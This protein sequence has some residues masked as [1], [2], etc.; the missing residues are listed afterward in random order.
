MPEVFQTSRR[1][2]FRDTDAA[3]IVHFSN[4]F[5][6]ME[7]AEHAFLRSLGLGVMCEIDGTQVSWPRVHAEC[8]YRNAIRFEEMIDVAVSI[9]RI[10]S[11][12]VTY[13]FQFFAG[14]NT[15]GGWI[16]HRRLLPAATR[17]KASI[18]PHSVSVRRSPDSVS[19]RDKLVVSAYL[20]VLTI[21]LAAGVGRLSDSTRQQHARYFL[22]AQQAD[23]GFGGR[24]GDSDLYYTAFALRALS[25]LG[26][27]YGDVAE[28]AEQFLKPQLASHQTIV[29]FFSLFYAANLLKVASGKD[30]FADS[31]PN[32]PDQV[33]G[34]WNHCD[35]LTVGTPKH[36]KGMV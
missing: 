5:I 10:G 35:D 36:R 19:G 34:F 12:S 25:I 26:E 15:R 18:D 20:Q 21:R 27:L 31:D 32:W 30:I 8:N 28:R 24:E 2:E 22:D 11:S 33:A 14:L 23:G 16:D 3:G 13:R 17:T 1:V 7:Q 4:F 29:D 6:Y 9:N